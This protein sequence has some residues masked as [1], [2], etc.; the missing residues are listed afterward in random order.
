LINNK[1]A[2]IAQYD[3]DTIKTIYHTVS[4][5]QIPISSLGTKQ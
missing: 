5:W 1:D 3:D 2:I 4:H